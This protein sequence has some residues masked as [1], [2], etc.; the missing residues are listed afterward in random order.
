MEALNVGKDPENTSEKGRRD[1]S[2]SLPGSKENTSQAHTSLDD[3]TKRKETVKECLCSQSWITQPENS[4]NRSLA[5]EW[6]VINLLVL[7]IMIA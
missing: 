3:V 5:R 6:M 4:D 1:I 7:T 2:I